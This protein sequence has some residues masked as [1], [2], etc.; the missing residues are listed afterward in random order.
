[1]SDLSQCART[2]DDLCARVLPARRQEIDVVFFEALLA[3]ALRAAQLGHRAGRPRLASGGSRYITTFARCTAACIAQAAPRIARR[4]V[5]AGGRRMASPKET[6]EKKEVAILI[7]RCPGMTVQN[8]AAITR[9]AL[10]P[11]AGG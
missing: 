9:T 5:V 8:A 1:R 6:Q 11:E 3:R 4:N 10:C 7:A 2:R